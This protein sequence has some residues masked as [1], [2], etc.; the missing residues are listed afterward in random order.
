MVN[1]VRINICFTD[2]DGKVSWEEFS[3][4]RYEDEEDQEYKEKDEKKFR[5]ADLNGDNQ[6]D[7]VE[8]LS[9]QNPLVSSFTKFQSSISPIYLLQRLVSIT[10][11]NHCF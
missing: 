11:Y 2:N 7:S 3:K 9:Y 6:L 4:G 10:T 1:R 8:Y 5:Q